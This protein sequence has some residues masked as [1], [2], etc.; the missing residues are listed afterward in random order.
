MDSVDVQL[1]D[2]AFSCGVDLGQN[3][4]YSIIILALIVTLGRLTIRSV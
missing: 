1:F 2:Y 3:L 4:L